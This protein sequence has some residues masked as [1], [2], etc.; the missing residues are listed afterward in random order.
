MDMGR[1]ETGEY[2]EISAETHQISDE[3]HSFPLPEVWHAVNAI[4]SA[5]HPGDETCTEQDSTPAI[6]SAIVVR[7]WTRSINKCIQTLKP[8]VCLSVGKVIDFQ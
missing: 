3:R 2:K 5:T 4:Q 6:Y 8:W 7:T 1:C